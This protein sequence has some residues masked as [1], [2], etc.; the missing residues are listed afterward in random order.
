M[1]DGTRRGE[2]LV[3]ADELL[4]DIELA[5]IDPVAVARKAGRL[6]RLLDDA[7]AMRWLAYETTGYPSGALDEHSAYAAVRSSRIEDG[8]D[9]PLVTLVPLGQFAAEIEAATLELGSDGGG[10]SS[11]EYAVIVE[12]ENAK[13]RENTR[14][15]IATRRKVLDRVVGAIHTYVAERHQELRFG[16]AVETAFNVVRQEV[17]KAIAELVPDAL[18]MISAAFENASSDKEEHWQN[19]ASTCRRLLMTAADRLRPPGPDVDSRKMGSNNYVNRLVDWI[20]QQGTGETA[21][22]MIAS[23]LQYLG[24]RLDAADGAGQKGAHVGEKR[25]SR[26]EASRFV[27][28]TYLA[29]GDILRIRRQSN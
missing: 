6:A 17:D 1:Q 9:G 14:N 11:S 5:R 27:T 26:S 29:L 25:V 19:A 24:L 7:D 22:A 28:G 21:S 15:L 18:P 23:D 3:L 2:A 12:R 20:V 4:S 13:R 8:A 16:S 10:V